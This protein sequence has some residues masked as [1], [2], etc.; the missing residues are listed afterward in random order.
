MMPQEIRLAQ[1]AIPINRRDRRFYIWI[2][3]V[4]AISPTS[5]INPIRDGGGAWETS[6]RARVGYG[7]GGRRSCPTRTPRFGGPT[8]ET[9]GR[10]ERSQSSGFDQKPGSAEVLRSGAGVDLRVQPRRG[11]AVVRAGGETRPEDGHGAVGNRAGRRAQ[12][13]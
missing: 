8:G 2:I 10:L 4:Y 3:Y 12:L 6:A 5:E 9:D 1:H 11:A 7:I 13:Q